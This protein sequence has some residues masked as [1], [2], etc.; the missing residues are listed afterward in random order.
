M[1]LA[2]DRYADVCVPI[3]FRS[4]AAFV[5]LERHHVPPRRSRRGASLGCNLNLESRVAFRRYRRYRRDR[6]R[7]PALVRFAH[8]HDGE[9]AQ[10]VVPAHPERPVVDARVPQLRAQLVSPHLAPRAPLPAPLLPTPRVTDSQ[11]PKRAAGSI[12]RVQFNHLILRDEGSEFC[13]P[14]HRGAVKLAYLHHR[15]RVVTDDADVRVRRVTLRG[16]THRELGGGVRDE[17]GPRR[18]RVEVRFVQF[19]RLRGAPGEV[20][21]PFRD[22]PAADGVVAP[23]ALGVRLLDQ[24]HP[25]LVIRG[26]RVGECEFIV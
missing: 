24:R 15:V 25:E 8:V 1:R 13:L 22:P 10:E 23:V 2:I 11:Q 21:K 18:L 17:F 26:S 20:Q 5:G 16:A 3:P 7:V 19:D 12:A 9:P 6:Y 4:E 14:T